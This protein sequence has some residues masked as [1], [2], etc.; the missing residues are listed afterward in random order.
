M[1]DE[2]VVKSIDSEQLGEELKKYL[3]EE[4][5]SEDRDER[6][7]WNTFHIVASVVTAGLYLWAYLGYEA[8]KFY[9]QTDADLTTEH[10]LVEK[11]E[12]EDEEGE[13]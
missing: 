10:V 8:L 3:Q 9:Q 11:E 13:E 6:I 2:D 1:T 7:M 5:D 12:H 4:R